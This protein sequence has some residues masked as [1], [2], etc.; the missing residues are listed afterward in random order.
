MMR[1]LAKIACL[2]VLFMFSGHCA[3]SYDFEV[4]GIYY[5]YN[6]QNQTATVTSSG[7]SEKYSGNIVIPP[8]VTFNGR[9]MPVLTIG[10]G[11]FYGC[12]G[13]ESVS[14]PEGL[15]EIGD[16]AFRDCSILS[17]IKIPT[18]VTHIGYTA[19]SGCSALFTID[20]PD[21]VTSIAGSTFKDCTSLISVSFP[22]K[23]Y[24]IGSSAFEG[25]SKLQSIRIPS[26]TKYIYEKAFRNCE[27]LD[28]I[29]FENA[30]N[31][32]NLH[33]FQADGEFP[34]NTCRP[35]A[36]YFGRPIECYP[37]E[38]ARFVS[39]A[40][41]IS[42][43]NN[44]NLKDMSFSWNEKLTTI[45][46]FNENPQNTSF[47][48]FDTK[49]YFN[50]T[51]YVPIG[52]KQKYMETDGWKNFFNIQEMDVAD[53]WH[54]DNEIKSN[55]DTKEKC[56][57]PTIRYSNGK[58]LFE[59]ATE[60]AVCQSSITNSDIASHSGNEVQLGV[61][62]HISV[63]ATAAGYENSDVST[64]TLCW[65]DIDPKTEGVEN[66][67]SQVIA[68]AIL[69]Q[70]NNGIFSIDGVDSGTNISI[71]NIAGVMVGSKKASDGTVSIN[72]DMKRGEVAIIKIGEK[73]VKVVM[74]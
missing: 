60:G 48:S 71:Y 35:K 52:T 67:L 11:A 32:I 65:V 1:Q 45:Y 16:D 44:F 61:T 5:N 74:K 47:L 41:I 33:F 42:V 59:S 72:T 55:D 7:T 34:F 70:S 38:F 57:K 6:S 4:G 31:S 64:A 19:F 12:K 66:G 30:T 18:T 54:G 73:S 22:V 26:W 37:S 62:Y 20:I 24:S 46:S 68:N 50:S 14:L 17:A 63:Y 3:Y 51:L 39:E 43:S 23:L 21:N 9:T 40:E 13:L 29:V 56:E 36:I 53:M 15:S 10:N 8:S 28:T 25:C 27:H 2:L 49:V 69:I 58:L